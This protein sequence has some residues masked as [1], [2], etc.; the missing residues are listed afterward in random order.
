MLSKSV[1]RNVTECIRVVLLLFGLMTILLNIAD[2]N[3]NIIVDFVS[4]LL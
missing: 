2:L 3:A 4:G 1:L